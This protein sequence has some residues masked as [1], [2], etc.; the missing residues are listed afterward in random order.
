MDNLFNMIN[1]IFIKF[2]N[3]L[4]E[5]ISDLSQLKNYTN[6]DIII[7]R[8][9]FTMNKLNA[10]INENNNYVEL[11]KSN[12]YDFGKKYDESTTIVN[13]NIKKEEIKYK[14]GKYIGQVLNGLR[15]GKGIY[16]YN[17]GD[18]YEGFWKNNK[19]DGKG[20]YYYNDGNR[21]EGEWKNGIKEGKGIYYYND[22]DRYEGDFK[23]D[24]YDGR[25]IY[26]YNDGERYEGDWIDDKRQGK[27]IYYYNN[28]DK[29]F[30]DYYKDKPIGKHVKFTKDGKIKMKNY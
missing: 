26:Y 2:Y 9:D 21:Y 7:V 28:G 10:I 20:I 8:L 1:K 17:N 4:I 11:I 13:N 3:S 24:R 25:G 14:D 5:I 6:D 27:G 15:E 18:K 29:R 22:G 12:I 23:N 19:K 30:G 16:Y